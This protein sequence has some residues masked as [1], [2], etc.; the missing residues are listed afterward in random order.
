MP[1]SATFDPYELPLSRDSAVITVYHLSKEGKINNLVPNV[2]CEQIQYRSGQPGSAR[3]RYITDDNAKGEGYPTRFDKIF[4]FDAAGGN[5]LKQDYRVGVFRELGDGEKQILFDGFVQ[6]PQVDLDPESQ[7]VT[8]TALATPIR[9]FDDK[10]RGAW[11]R[12]ADDVYEGQL[13]QTKLP[14]RFNPDGKPNATPTAWDDEEDPDFPHPAFLPP[15]YSPEGLD[16]ATYWTLGRAIRYILAIY[17]EEDHVSNPSS[18]LLSFDA[19]D[20]QLQA[21]V[22]KDGNLIDEDDALS[23]EYKDIVVRDFDAT[24]LAWP[25]AV[26]R[27]IEQHGFMMEFLLD[28]TWDSEDEDATPQWEVRFFRV[29]GFLEDAPKSL[30]IQEPG[31]VLDPGQTNVGSL[32]LARDTAAVANHIV[33]NSSPTKYEVSVILAP[34][35]TPSA[36]DATNRDQF[37]RSKMTSANK[38]KYRKYIFDECGEGHWN[39]RTDTYEYEPGNFDKELADDNEWVKR[40]RP[41]LSKLI[42]KDVRGIPLKY[43][44]WVS[45]DYDGPVCDLWAGTGTWQEIS[46][47]HRLLDDRLGIYFDVEDPEDIHTGSP[48]SQT[49]GGMIRGIT[50]SATPDTGIY[51]KFYIRLDCVIEGDDGC[52]AVAVA[53]PASPSQFTLTRIIDARDHFKKEGIHWSSPSYT[54]SDDEIKWVRDDTEKAKDY[55][56]AIQRAS[57]YAKFAGTATIPR[58]TVAYSIGDRISKI[59]GI[60]MSL[61][62]NA[63]EERESPMYPS[64]VGIDWTFGRMQTTTLYLSDRRAE[65]LRLT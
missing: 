36:G 49:K 42:T 19:L 52:D 45:T 53:R 13:W 48:G 10:I 30:K 2:V 3:F 56:E 57:E 20:N 50:A 14:T 22:P 65:P 17:N 1:G 5:I 33:V 55:A 47:G 58:F 43:K 61:K 64:I 28:R 15:G 26:S 18:A 54:G 4:P 40:P 37:R 60:N 21:V 59:D 38:D 62:S 23:Y 35:F 27:L 46:S 39:T 8:F 11:Y 25:E 6:I 12:D 7:P 16:P 32:K 41:A 44:A 51:K 29:D 34:G 24:G 63:G 9:C 31:S